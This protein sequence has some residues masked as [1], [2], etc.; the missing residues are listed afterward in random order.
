ALKRIRAN[1]L[2]VAERFPDNTVADENLQER[3][4]RIRQLFYEGESYINTG[5][6]PRAESK[7][8]EILKIDRY[9]KVAM[10]KLK[11]I[12]AL[13]R[14]A[15]ILRRRAMKEKAMADV[16]ENWDEIRTRRSMEADSVI[17]TQSAEP[18][19]VG[20]IFDKLE[21]IRI[22]ELN[23]TDVDVA[24]AVAY[25]QEQSKALDPTGEG[26]NFVLKAQSTALPGDNE[27]EEVQPVD[28]TIN[29]LTLDL[30]D[31]PLIKVLE[32]IST[33]TNL[34]FKVEEFAVYI[35]PANETSDVKVVRSFSVPPTFFNSTT[36]EE[37]EAGTDVKGELENKGV[38]FSADTSAAYL[39]KT[40]KL[41]VR[42]TL[43][44][45][46]LI[47][48]LVAKESGETIQISIETKFIEFS[49]DKLKDFSSNLRIRADTAI[50]APFNVPVSA[51]NN[52]APLQSGGAAFVP[53]VNVDAFNN[54]TGVAGA[55][56]IPDFTTNPGA[57]NAGKVRAGLGTALRNSGSLNPNRLDSLLGLGINRDPA[58]LGFSGVLG[59]NGFRYLLTALE[60]NFGSDLMSAPKVTLINGQTSKI[61]VVREFFY[62][63]EYEPPEVDLSSTGNGGATISLVTVTPSNPTDFVSKD[64]GVILDVKANATPDRRIDLEL[65]PE[66]TEF[67]GFI[68]Y[69]ESVNSATTVFPGVIS[70]ITTADNLQP[71]FS[72]RKIETKI[73]VIDGQTVVMA[74]F[75][76]NDE[77]EIDDKVPFLGDL[78][79]VGRAFRSKTT[80][81]VKRNLVLFVTAR[82]I[83]PDGTPKFLTEQE[84]EAFGL[85]NQVQ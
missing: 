24:D 1:S 5:Q 23:F 64:L 45:I 48:Q 53:P 35:F 60:S 33:L 82:M 52:G 12:A 34:K 54:N 13:K 10:K 9:N 27:G 51:F 26:V 77:Q 22:P 21:T 59:S 50:P 43:E 37:G 14:Q 47:E 63:E 42:N 18:S 39:P 70:Q 65:V 8:N 29:T 25:L 20:L 72:V 81:S 49:E 74:G 36:L 19:N 84:A 57:G 78:P 3:V 46:S 31:M 17:D 55:D 80:Q 69:G 15:S 41:V 28:D 6:Y 4:N 71:V 30:R 58:T 73:Q 67:Q 11:E 66:V 85:A 56:G 83:N 62:P 61:R 44:Q 75:I 68:N 40:A 16:S 2:T 76:R 79:L 7:Y 32:F 38:T